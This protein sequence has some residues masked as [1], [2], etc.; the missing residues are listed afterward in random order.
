MLD[1][2]LNSPEGQSTLQVIA[3]L[4]PVLLFMGG[5]ITVH[6]LHKREVYFW[7]LGSTWTT[8]VACPLALV[9]I[10]FS[11]FS[12]LH[13]P[14]APLFQA[15]IIAGA[16]LYVSAVAYALFYNFNA[17]KSFILAIS[18]S[19]LQQVAVL[20]AVFLFLRWSGDHQK[21]NE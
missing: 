3:V 7:S 10:C 16:L 6:A 5:I 20:G 19:L 1:Y 8:V 13:N 21:R 4:L 9:I 14:N 17:T 12:R 11:V 18:T 2:L 15:P